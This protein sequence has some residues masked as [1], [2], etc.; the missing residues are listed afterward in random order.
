MEHGDCKHWYFIV[1]DYLECSVYLP[2]WWLIKFTSDTL[3]WRFT[4]E[5]I[6]SV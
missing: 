1:N 6:A 5:N 4:N 2:T 3:L